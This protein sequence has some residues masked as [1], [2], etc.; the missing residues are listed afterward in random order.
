MRSGGT[1]RIA[2]CAAMVL[3]AGGLMVGEAEASGAANHPAPA[4]VAL[5]CTVSGQPKDRGALTDA[6]VCGRFLAR[7]GEALDLPVDRAGHVPAGAGARWVKLAIRLLPRGRAEA[8]V[9]SRL[10]GKATSHPAMAVQVMDKP[11]DLSDID[12]L[13]RL[14]GKTLAGH[15]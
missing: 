7:I 14:A 13:A 9:T 5:V 12:K 3:F 6:A 11:M 15:H 1:I 8:A 10:H 4:P 2:A